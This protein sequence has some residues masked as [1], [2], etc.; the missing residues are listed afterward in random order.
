MPRQRQQQ[1]SR[2][3]LSQ[4]Y[5]DIVLLEP[6]RLRQVTCYTR[7]ML[8]KYFPAFKYRDFRLFW[9]ADLISRVGTQLLTV[10]VSWHLYLLTHSPFALGLIG[11]VQLVPLLICNLFAGAV[12]DVHNRK[13]I[14]YVTQFIMVV[15]SLAL[16]LATY[17]HVI[18]PSIIY[19]L[20]G[21]A[22]VAISFYLPAY[23]SVLPA[24][25]DQKDLSAANSTL[26]LQE[27]ISEMAGPAAAG[28]LIASIGVANLYLLDALS[29]IVAVVMLYRM[30]FNGE[31][32]GERPKVS[33]GAVN[34]G[35]RFLISQKVLWSSMMLDTLSVLFAS[36][37]VLMPIFANDILHV[38]PQGLGLLYAAPAIGA[39]CIGFF[40]S[41][42]VSIYRQGKVLLLAVAMYAL[43]TIVFGLSRSFLLSIVALVVVGGANVISVTI[44]AV[45]RQVF[46]P[47]TMRGRVYSFYSFFWIA[48]DKVGDIEGGFLAQLIGASGTVAVGGVAALAVVGA[49]AVLNPNLRN[50]VHSN[51]D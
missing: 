44:R 51:K 37:I 38:G 11:V 25:V 8:S 19:V 43:A 23:G 33:F 20:I 3:R 13:T 4:F 28:L 5:S 18:S 45:I 26:T 7:T 47:D 31:Q 40:L 22:A 9:S 10:A 24:I 15:T 48:G 46:T 16:G 39:V 41:R 35:Y 30:T 50:Y 49:M 21:I 42:G 27:D 14:L 17:A 1:A 36:S 32:A 2:K 34:E 12:A 29:T 6:S